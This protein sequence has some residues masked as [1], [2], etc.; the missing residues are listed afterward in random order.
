MAR[1]L[2]IHLKVRDQV[3]KTLD[4]K[5]SLLST[6]ESPRSQFGRMGYE[7]VRNARNGEERVG[8]RRRPLDD[9]AVTHVAFGAHHTAHRGLVATRRRRCH[10]PPLIAFRAFPHCL[11]RHLVRGDPPP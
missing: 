8:N 6:C 11:R 2:L 3:L 4:R 7:V 9:Q 10:A 5:R 1:L